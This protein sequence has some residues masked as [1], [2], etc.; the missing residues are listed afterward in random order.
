MDAMGAE[1]CTICGCNPGTACGKCRNGN[2]ERCNAKR[3]EQ[4]YT[5]QKLEK[6]LLSLAETLAPKSSLA[7]LAQ[8][9]REA[10]LIGQTKTADTEPAFVESPTPRRARSRADA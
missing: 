7:W 3:T 6:V 8:I 9:L 10:D 2:C 1:I 4:Y 5:Q